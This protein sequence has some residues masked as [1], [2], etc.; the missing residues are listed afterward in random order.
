MF[1]PLRD[2]NPTTTTPYVTYVLI[3]LNAAIFLLE[4]TLGE[5]ALNRVYHS[6][7]VVP[8][9]LIADPVGRSF[10]LLS[11]M[12]LH[13]GWMH[14]IGNMWFLYIFGDNIEDR[15]GKPLYVVFYLASGIAAAALQVAIQPASP[16]PTIGASGAI[17]G[18]LGGYA[19]IYPQA[20]VVT[21]VWIFIFVRMLHIP[22]VVYLGI[23][24]LMQFLS[25][26]G[27][28]GA[29]G[30]GGVAWWAHVG[31]FA[32]GGAVGLYLRSRGG[33]G[34]PRRRRLRTTGDQPGVILDFDPDRRRTYH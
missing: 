8:A 15:L 7:G 13:G 24:F 12:F 26:V 10:T 2:E 3:A 23:W 29:G 9:A 28:L 6:F 25:G 32:V 20:R 33:P 30:G 34:R 16:I 11:S 14:L 17:A 27:S 5:D 22:A 1:I 19:L 18:V 31:G 4:V 21:L